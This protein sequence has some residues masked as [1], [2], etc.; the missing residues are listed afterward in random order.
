MIIGDWVEAIT[1]ETG[2]STPA[3]AITFSLPV[4]SVAGLRSR[5]NT[6]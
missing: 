3:G 1:R 5:D 6:E 4:S 2:P